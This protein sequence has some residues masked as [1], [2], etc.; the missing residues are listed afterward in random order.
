MASISRKRKTEGPPGGPPL[1][2]S[3]SSPVREKKIEETSIDFEN[4]QK[5]ILARDIAEA[6]CTDLYRLQTLLASNDPIDFDVLVGS[7]EYI[8]KFR[9]IST[10]ANCLS[11]VDTDDVIE[12]LT[13][14]FNPELYLQLLVSLI[15]HNQDNKNTNIILEIAHELKDDQVFEALIQALVSIEELEFKRYSVKEYPGI[16]KH[17]QKMSNITKKAMQQA[18][19]NS[20]VA[21]SGEPLGTNLSQA[22]I[23][24]LLKSDPLKQ[25]IIFEKIKLLGVPELDQ[26]TEEYSL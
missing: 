14:K 6:A 8:A 18:I 19:V 5:E 22:F 10:S 17:Q 3:K 1:K 24:I 26:I 12:I 7:Y 16:A 21:L 11:L 2:E 9:D 25:Q 13:L 23:E 20:L 4:Y 15:L